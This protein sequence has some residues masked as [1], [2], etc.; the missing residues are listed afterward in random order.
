MSVRSPPIPALRAE[1]LFSTVS[2][3]ELSFGLG[4]GGGS[5]RMKRIAACVVA[6]ACGLPL[7]C[8]AKSH[9]QVSLPAKDSTVT[10]SPEKLLL[11]FSE[12]VELTS[13]T[14]QREGDKEPVHVTQLPPLP[15]RPVSVRLPRLGPGVYTVRYWVMNSDLRETRGSFTFTLQEGPDWPR[16]RR[17]AEA[18]AH[19]RPLP[20][21]ED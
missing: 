2:R 10:G 8:F 6:L 19:G 21:T 7:V 15:G 16:A 12:A 13:L 3:K 18:L 9:L 14:L 20:T 1:K 11:M 17:T 4:W 5:S